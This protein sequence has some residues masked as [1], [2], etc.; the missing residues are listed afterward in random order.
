MEGQRSLYMDADTRNALKA[1]HLMSGLVAV[2][3]NQNRLLARLGIVTPDM[4]TKMESASTRGK[5]IATYV[6]FRNS[7]ILFKKIHH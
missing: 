3:M 6:N 5:I 7:Y 2:S 4:C 1:R